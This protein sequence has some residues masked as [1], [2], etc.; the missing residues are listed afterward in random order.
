MLAVGSLPNVIL[1][2]QLS[3]MLCMPVHH[4][5]RSTHSCLECEATVTAAIRRATL[6][7]HLLGTQ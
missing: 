2:M 6:A 1:E 4:M 7:H 3:D 5:S